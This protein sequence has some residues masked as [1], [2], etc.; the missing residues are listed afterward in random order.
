MGMT[1]SPVWHLC[2]DGLIGVMSLAVAEQIVDN[3]AADGEDED[4]ER[5]NDLAGDGTV[6]LENLD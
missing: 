3:H 2:R 5:P 4:H 6:G 1:L